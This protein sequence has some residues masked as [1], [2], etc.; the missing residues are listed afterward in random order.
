MSHGEVPDIPDTV[1]KVF[2]AAAGFRL[3]SVTSAAG[4]T[5]GETK[6]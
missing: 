5:V 1:L 6:E 3:L 4:A 2:T